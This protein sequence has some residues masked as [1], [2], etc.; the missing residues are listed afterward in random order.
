MANRLTAHTANIPAILLVGI[1]STIVV[2]ILILVLGLMLT[3]LAAQ[4]VLSEFAT[5]PP[6]LATELA[7]VRTAAP[8]KVFFLVKL[9][10]T[11][12]AR[13]HARVE[14]AFTLNQFLDAYLGLLLVHRQLLASLLKSKDFLD[15]VTIVL[16]QLVYRFLELDFAVFGCSLV[17]GILLLD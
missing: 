9:S 1:V 14:F 8:I 4:L 7:V 13:L 12:F 6:H 10:A 15:M 17:H 16:V 3:I 2:V 11:L 5:A